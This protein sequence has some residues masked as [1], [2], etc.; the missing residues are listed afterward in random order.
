MGLSNSPA[1][2]YL[3]SLLL[4]FFFLEPLFSI[5]SNIL[6]INFSSCKSPSVHFSSCTDRK[7]VKLVTSTRHISCFSF[8]FLLSSSYFSSRYTCTAR[9]CLCQWPYVCQLCMSRR[10]L[11]RAQASDVRECGCHVTA[12]H[13]SITAENYRKKQGRSHF[14]SIVFIGFVNTL[15]ATGFFF[16]K[17]SARFTLSQ[18]IRERSP[19]AEDVCQRIP[20][21]LELDQTWRLG[22]ESRHD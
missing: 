3:L 16:I 20:I 17:L 15:D 9:F 2:S 13:A 5:Q 6:E 22:T 11:A 19:G 14:S 8:L 7:I 18:V 21:G 10:F 1:Y 4:T 12:S